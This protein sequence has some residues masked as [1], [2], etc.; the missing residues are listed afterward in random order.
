MLLRKG[1]CCVDLRTGAI[2]L[3]VL[4]II[5]SFCLLFSGGF[6]SEYI[7]LV[8]LGLSTYGCLLFGA[9]KNNRTATLIS[10]VMEMIYIVWM[11]IVL[12]LLIAL[13][14]AA[15]VVTQSDS[16][17]QKSDAD[18]MEMVLSLIHI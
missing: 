10:L 11:V 9:I 7:I 5:N 16:G 14:T 6:D 4:G 1:F 3:A 18:E 8:I 2:V 17:A 13:G 12:I 15:T